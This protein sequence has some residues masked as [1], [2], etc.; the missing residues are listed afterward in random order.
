M[1]QIKEANMGCVLIAPDKFKGTLTAAQVAAHVAAGLGRACPGL[2]TAL[3]PVADGGDG[4]VDAAEAAGFRRVEIGVRGPT[5]KPLTASFALLDGTAVIESAQACGLTRLP[6]GAA[7]PLT[8]TSRGVG[9]LILAA[10]RMRAKR[11][12]LGLG[13]VACTDGG[14]GLVTALGGRL[15]DASGTELSPGGAELARLDHIDV[16][17]LRDLSGT[18][19]EVIAATDVDNPLLGPRGAAAVY[20][21]QKGASADDVAVL[22]DGLTRWADVAE[23][24]LGFRKRDEPGA[25][26][27]GGLGFA[28][29]GFLGAVMQPGIDLMLDLLSFGS[30]LP[31]ARLVIT[32]EGALDHQTLHGKAP[33]GV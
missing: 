17:R 5:G 13:G 22:E 18:G 9:E 15:L 19:T 6:G 32:G 16:S 24:A 8:A 21:P 7:A 12:V 29:L 4:T 31:G 20:A 2:T 23:Q 28:A 1:P 11:I 26:A 33:A 10:V 14:A 30:H 25:G 3:V 27:A